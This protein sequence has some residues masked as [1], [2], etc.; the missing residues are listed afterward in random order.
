MRGATA[1]SICSN[2]GQREGADDQALAA[3]A[4]GLGSVRVP[5]REQ[6]CWRAKYYLYIK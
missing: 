2:P 4:G 5:L 3:V 6:A 1:G